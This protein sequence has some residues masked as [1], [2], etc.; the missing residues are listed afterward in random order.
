GQSIGTVIIDETGGG[1]KFTP[2]LK[3]LPPAEHDFHIHANR[4]CQPT[5]KDGNA[6]A[7]EAAGGHLLPQNT[8]KHEGPEGQCNLGDL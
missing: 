2:Q 3:A 6:G 4:S 8:G 5:M 7:A 1:L